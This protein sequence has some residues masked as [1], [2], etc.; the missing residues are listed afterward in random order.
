[1][2]DCLSS[3]RGSIPLFTAKSLIGGADKVGVITYTTFPT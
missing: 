2:L 1:M 3:A